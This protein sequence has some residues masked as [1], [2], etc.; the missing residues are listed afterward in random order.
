MRQRDKKTMCTR[1]PGG[2]RRNENITRGTRRQRNKK[3][4]EQKDQRHK[5]TRGNN[6]TP[7]PPFAHSTKKIG[8]KKTMEQEDR[9]HEMTRQT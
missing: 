4:K 9:G 6:Q 1:S 8:N 3:T 7:S 2:T 5:M